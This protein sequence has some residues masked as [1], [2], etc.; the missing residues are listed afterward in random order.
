MTRIIKILLTIL[1]LVLILSSSAGLQAQET[2]IIDSTRQ[3]IENKHEPD[4]IKTGTGRYGLFLQTGFLIARNLYIDDPW[5]VSGPLPKP[6][7]RLALPLGGIGLYYFIRENVM[8]GIDLASMSFPE[9]IHLWGS[10]R[11][12]SILE[13]SAHLKYIS[14]PSPKISLYLKA[15]LKMAR[16]SGTLRPG[17]G[18]FGGSVGSS[19][20]TKTAFAPGWELAVGLMGIPSKKPALFVEVAFSYLLMKGKDVRA[21]GEAAAGNYPF[22]LVLYGVRVGL[23]IPIGGKGDKPKEFDF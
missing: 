1:S 18:L 22:N 8:G 16:L 17:K 11:T 2:A 15:G 23:M 6:S 9:C 10:H 4:K 13:Y 19:L 7:T 21:N 3:A 5:W 14:K 20:K 12:W